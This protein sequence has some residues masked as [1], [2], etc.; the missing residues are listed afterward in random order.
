[1][2]QEKYLLKINKLYVYLNY[3]VDLYEYNYISK[4]RSLIENKY[5]N[6]DQHKLIKFILGEEDKELVISEQNLVQF[7]K[8]VEFIWKLDEQS[9]KQLNAD[10]P[11]KTP[12]TTKEEVHYEKNVSFN[13]EISQVSSFIYKETTNEKNVIEEYEE[14][15][16]VKVNLYDSFSRQQQQIFKELKTIYFKR[17]IVLR[18]S[19]GFIEKFNI[20]FDPIF[21]DEFQKIIEKLK[22]NFLLKDI[23]YC[24]QNEKWR[25]E[26]YNYNQNNILFGLSKYLKLEKIQNMISIEKSKNIPFKKKE[27]KDLKNNDNLYDLEEIENEID[28]EEENQNQKEDE[29]LSNSKEKENEEE[30]ENQEK[31]EKKEI[32]EYN[33]NKELANISENKKGKSKNKKRNMTFQEFKHKFKNALKHQ[34]KE[35]TTNDLLEFIMDPDENYLYILYNNVYKNNP[36]K[37]FIFQ[38]PFLILNYIFIDINAQDSS[39]LIGRNNNLIKSV[40]TN[41]KEEDAEYSADSKNKNEEKDSSESDMSESS[42]NSEENSNESQKSKN[43]SDETQKEEEQKI[44]VKEKEIRDEK[45]EKDEDKSDEKIISENNSK[46]ESSSKTTETK[47]KKENKNF[48][49][50]SK[51]SIFKYIPSKDLNKKKHLLSKDRKSKK[52]KKHFKKKSSDL[53]NFKFDFVED[54]D[55]KENSSFLRANQKEK[56]FIERIDKIFNSTILYNDEEEENKKTFALIQMKNRNISNILKTDD[57]SSD[58]SDTLIKKIKEYKNRKKARLFL[59]ASI[60][61]RKLWDNKNNKENKNINDNNKIIYKK[62]NNNKFLREKRQEMQEIKKP[63]KELLISLV[64]NDVK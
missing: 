48:T 52:I 58:M 1:M 31:S 30:E 7:I 24:F 19:L 10:N 57:N 37:N 11:P 49:I 45:D 13:S 17:D 54:L 40:I 44:E 20:N 26:L 9:L 22:V 4:T 35:N 47:N 41:V 63:R 16:E 43:K 25:D 34:E 2:N 6:E 23:F 3:I 60:K 51:V 53:F 46:S 15:I 56:T 55:L 18:D 50:V 5:K 12:V 36:D 39:P 59:L 21:A 28:Y 27:I 32:K 33:F 61:T 8:V 42:E 64:K 38:N 62:I 29:W 14:D